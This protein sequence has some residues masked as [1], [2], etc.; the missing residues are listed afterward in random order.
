MR[1]AAFALALFLAFGCARFPTGGGGG[2]TKRFRFTIR[3]AAPVNPQYVY[4][5][6]INDADDLTGQNGGPIPVI[7]RPWGNGFVAGRATHFVRYDGFLPNGGYGVFRFTDLVNLLTYFQTGV[8]VNFLTPGPGDDTLFFEIDAT[9]LRPDPM[10]AVL[11]RALQVNILTMDRVPT[12]PN[13]PNPK[14]WDALGDS[15]DPQ[16]INDYITI[17]TTTNRIYRN[18]DLQIEP[19]QD[20]PDPS[21]DIV[22]WTIEIR[23]Q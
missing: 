22:D 2:F 13:D 12:D 23:V 5:V 16:S 15:R 21:L 19:P 3:L 11:I 1:A 6:A 10:Q 20:T 14:T 4:I 8:P 18:A 7:Q 17:D 9:Q